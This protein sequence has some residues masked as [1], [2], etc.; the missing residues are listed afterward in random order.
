MNDQPPIYRLDSLLDE[1]VESFL[2]PYASNVNN[3]TETEWEVN[4][5][6]KVVMSQIF[7]MRGITEQK[8]FWSIC[9]W[10]SQVWDNIVLNVNVPEHDA[11]GYFAEFYRPVQLTYEGADRIY[12]RNSTGQHTY[13]AIEADHG[14]FTMFMIE[15]DRRYNRAEDWLGGLAF[16]LVAFLKARHKEIVRYEG[17]LSQTAA[18]VM[19][20]L[21]ELRLAQLGAQEWMDNMTMITED[22]GEIT[23]RSWGGRGII[24]FAFTNTNLI[25]GT[26]KI[27]Q[28]TS[29]EGLG[30]EVHGYYQMSDIHKHPPHIT[31]LILALLRHIG[32]YRA[33]SIAFDDARRVSDY[34]ILHEMRERER[35]EKEWQQ[36]LDETKGE[37]HVHPYPQLEE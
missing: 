10:I 26:N 5:F 29:A 13:V 12:W 16:G 2:F 8:R 36:W 7:T 4:H 1:Y 35:L 37:T 15:F 23:F 9:A 34:R 25:T 28:I 11:Y 27:C 33:L 31:Y 30:Q 3:I 22:T 19:N 20:S 18:I 24:T 17:Q 32:S 21:R 14:Q 6:M